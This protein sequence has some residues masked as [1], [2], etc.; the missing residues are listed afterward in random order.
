ML[1]ISS[2]IDNLRSEFFYG[3]FKN[4][5]K[6]LAAPTGFETQY[7]LIFINFSLSKLVKELKKSYPGLVATYSSVGPCPNF[8]FYL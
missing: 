7:N 4:E 3:E 6:M 2:S 5:R 1:K 8:A